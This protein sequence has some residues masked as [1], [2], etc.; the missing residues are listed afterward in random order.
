MNIILFAVVTVAASQINPYV[1]HANVQKDWR[2]LS[3]FQNIE[4]CQKA[5]KILGLEKFRCINSQTGEEK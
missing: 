1:S 5:A 2:E 3:R 4:A